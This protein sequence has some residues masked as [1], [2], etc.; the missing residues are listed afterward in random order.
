MSAAAEPRRMRLVAWKPLRKGSLIGFAE[1]ELPIGLKIADVPVLASHG[2]A[3]ASL[4]SKP[5]LDRDGRHAVD[6][7]GKKRYTPILAWADRSTADR[8]SDAVI[9]LVLAHHPEALD[10]DGGVP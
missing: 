3:W 10:G 7:R 1:L 5:L 4:P 2:K 8:W 6:E 9:S